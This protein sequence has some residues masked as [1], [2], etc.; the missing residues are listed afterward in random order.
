MHL[1]LVQ[2]W[3]TSLAHGRTQEGLTVHA[4]VSSA[5]CHGVQCVCARCTPQP[6]SSQDRRTEETLERVTLCWFPH[7]LPRPPQMYRLWA[8]PTVVGWGSVD[9]DRWQEMGQK[10]GI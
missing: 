10:G 5:V 7:P 3:T 4:S 8:L 6:T 9:Q 2:T 1:C